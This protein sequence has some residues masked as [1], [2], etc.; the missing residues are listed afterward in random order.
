MQCWIID[1]LLHNIYLNQPNKGIKFRFGIWMV[2]EDSAKKYIATL[3]FHFYHKS[4]VHLL[5]TD[6]LK[7]W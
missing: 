4:V 2:F 6:F 5:N 3:V 1:A 7:Y